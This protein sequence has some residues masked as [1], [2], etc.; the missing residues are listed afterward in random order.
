MKKAP[1]VSIYITNYNY[2]SYIKEAIESV[3]NQSFKDIELI[4]ID[5]GSTDNSREI[6]ESYAHLNNTRIIFQKN[7]GL[8]V[9]N[10]IAM[11]LA[12]GKYLVR[13]DADDYFS[14]DAIEKMCQKLESDSKL[15]LVFPDYFLIDS[16]GDVIAK[17]KNAYKYLSESIDLFP[18]QEELT[19]SLIEC[20]FE[21]VKTAN[22]FNGIVAIHTGYKV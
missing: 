8:N 6:I 13:L 17:D 7:K 2:G 11:R 18:S 16:L 19:K 12:H 15:G 14:E 20:G 3:L 4:I 10:N 1:L 21:K 9:T 5:D 22:L